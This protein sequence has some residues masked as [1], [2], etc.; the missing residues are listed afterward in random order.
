MYGE[1]HP[2]K[3]KRMEMTHSLIDTFGLLEKM[4]CYVYTK[5]NKIIYLETT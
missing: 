2:M 3:P 5:Q 1:N 4:D